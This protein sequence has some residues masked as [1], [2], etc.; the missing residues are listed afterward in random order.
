MI[1]NHSSRGEGALLHYVPISIAIILFFILIGSQLKCRRPS[2]TVAPITIGVVLG[3][4]G[5]TAEMFRMIK[6]LDFAIF[7]ERIYFVTSGDL[8]SAPKAQKFESDK[9]GKVGHLIGEA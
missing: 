4:G 9:H 5:H 3:S 1:H 6:D 8:L 2:R 7:D